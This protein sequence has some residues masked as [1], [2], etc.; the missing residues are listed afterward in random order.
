[1]HYATP[2]RIDS[3]RNRYLSS[4]RISITSRAEMTCHARREVNSPNVATFSQLLSIFKRNLGE[5]NDEFIIYQLFLSSD[6][7]PTSSK[8]KR[9]IIVYG[10]VTRYGPQTSCQRNDLTSKIAQYRKNDITYR[11]L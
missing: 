1:M 6:I 5:T 10:S 11:Y 9:R 8:R 3:C 4:F 2:F 7:I